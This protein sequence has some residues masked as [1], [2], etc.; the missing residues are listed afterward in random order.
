LFASDKMPWFVPGKKT[1]IFFGGLILGGVVGYFM[2][3]F[4]FRYE[5]EK[6]KVGRARS[7]LKRLGIA[8]E[9]YRA[10]HNIYPWSIEVLTNLQDEPPLLEPEDVLDPWGRHYMIWTPASP[11][12]GRPVF[13]SE[14]PPGKGKPIKIWERQ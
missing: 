11:E 3:A 9:I 8:A 1:A 14:G 13:Y 10:R 4:L 5:I 7:D 6:D 2:F 12:Y